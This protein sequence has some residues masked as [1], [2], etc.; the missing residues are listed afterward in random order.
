[1]VW[2]WGS[3]QPFRPRP[4]DYTAA[5]GAAAAA[6]WAGTAAEVAAAA[7]EVAATVAQRTGDRMVVIPIIPSGRPIKKNKFYIST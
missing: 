4:R 2:V 7:A 5:E 3:C 1:M 6:E